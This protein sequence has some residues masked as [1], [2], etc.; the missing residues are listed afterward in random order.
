MADAPTPQGQQDDDLFTFESAASKEFPLAPV[1]E[2]DVTVARA[3]FSMRE[4]S[5]KPEAGKQPTVSL[6]LSSTK[7]YNDDSSGEMKP[8]N[9]F[10]MMKISDHTKSGMFEFFRDIMGMTV[11]LVDVEKVAEDGTKTMA[12]KIQLA[13]KIEKVEGG[14]DRVHMPQFENLSFKVVVKHETK[15]D[16]KKRDFID[17][18]YATPEQIKANADLFRKAA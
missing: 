16:G 15:D 2:H 4:N 6:M 11:P 7:Q 8:Y 5:F 1:G 12:K 3:L 17:S 13:R 14:E 10:K 18:M 9:L